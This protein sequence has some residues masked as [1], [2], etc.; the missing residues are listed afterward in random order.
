M[1]DKLLK[2]YQDVLKYCGMEADSDGFVSTVINDT[3]QPA[4]I[5]GKRLVLPN[6]KQLS[7]ATATD[8]MIFHPLCENT[9]REESAVI[10]KLKEI[11]NIRLTYTFGI[12]C[13][14]LLDIAASPSIHNKL[15]PDQTEMLVAVKDVDKTSLQHFISI[16]VNGIKESP[17]K[18]FS[19]VY[20]KRGGSWKGKR[21]ARVG[22]VTFPLY[23]RLL[24]K[25][26]TIFNVK[27]R[28]KDYDIYQK[29]YS[30]IYPGIDSSTE[31]FNFGSN[32]E[33]APNFEALLKSSVNLAARLNDVIMLFSSYIEDYEKLMFDGNW[34]TD[35]EDISGLS[36]EIRKIPLQAGNEGDHVT[37]MSKVV[38][39]EIVM[40]VSQ[41]Q[42]VQQQ[43]QQ[44]APAVAPMPAQQYQQNI[45]QQGNGIKKTSK[46][47]DFRASMQ[48]AP[49]LAYQNNLLQNQLMTQEYQRMLASGAMMPGMAP[50][51]IPNMVPGMMPNNPML[52]Q[53]NQMQHMNPAMLPDHM[54]PLPSWCAP[55]NQMQMMQ[56]P[57]QLP[58]GMIQMPNGQI[59]HPSQLGMMANNGY[60][61]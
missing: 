59:L 27:L 48:A 34:I 24:A 4:T 56:G 39:P 14:S 51:M 31:Q 21:Y 36:S 43:V 41:P 45:Q 28:A 46:G 11:I 38:K 60:S 16:M 23:E 30:F 5:D 9:L 2:I 10:K 3:R 37:T 50:G 15:T 12:V 35:L 6:K 7:N 19:S 17:T 22:V 49:G 52:A 47:I 55:P 13:Q 1:S 25:E 8:K 20:I 57:V 33:A 18:L 44:Y 42:Q 26:D 40:P 58:N 29:L 32:S 61:I 53:M 54:R